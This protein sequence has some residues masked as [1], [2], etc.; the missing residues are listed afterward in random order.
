[1]RSVPRSPMP[2][3]AADGPPGDPLAPD[4]LRLALDVDAGGVAPAAAPA[5][6]TTGAVHVARWLG[7]AEQHELV[8]ACRAWAA[9]PAGLRR[10]H[11]PD[12]HRSDRQTVGRKTSL[13]R[14]WAIARLMNN[15][16]L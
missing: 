3:P 2:R 7:P 14:S 11:M 15:E 8:E 6:I 10:P 1:M 12:V 16:W 13:R 5:E 4:Q 9:P